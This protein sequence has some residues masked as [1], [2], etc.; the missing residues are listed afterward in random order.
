MARPRADWRA[1]AARDLY[2]GPSGN[3]LAGRWFDPE[4]AEDGGEWLAYRDNGN[5]RCSPCCRTLCVRARPRTWS[6]SYGLEKQL[7]PLSLGDGTVV[8]NEQRDSHSIRAQ[9]KVAADAMPGLRNATVGNVGALGLLV[10]Y[11]RI[12]QI[13]VAP[14]NATALLGGEKCHPCR[15]SLKPSA[16]RDSRAARSCRWSVPADWSTIHSMPRRSG[17]NPPI[18]AGEWTKTALPAGRRRPNPAPKVPG[19]PEGDLWVIAKGRDDH[20]AE[21]RAHLTVTKQS[22]NT[23]PIY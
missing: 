13:E 23:P 8:S 18:Q 17:E 9:V 10:I 20:H 21:G 3:Q 5:A 6:S 12:D 14:K 7:G 11:R 16:R 15:R 2:G 19:E 4:H 1:G 22:R